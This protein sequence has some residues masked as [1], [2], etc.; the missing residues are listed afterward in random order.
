VAMFA[1]RNYRGPWKWYAADEWRK[2]LDAWVYFIFRIPGF[3]II[4][5]TARN[6]GKGFYYT[7]YLL[8]DSSY[9]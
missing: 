5:H 6:L 3:R 1:P 2:M 8:V 7:I 4:R 9:G